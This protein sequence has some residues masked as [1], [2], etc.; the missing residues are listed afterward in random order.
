MPDAGDFVHLTAPFTFNGRVTGF[1]GDASSFPPIGPIGDPLFQLDLT[2]RGRARMHLV[3]IDERVAA[4]Q[5]RRMDY[6]FSAP[7]VVPEPG[8]LLLL[9]GGLAGLW[10]RRRRA[11]MTQTKSI[12]ADRG[13]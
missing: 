10:V 12:Q 2:G 5:F 1:A 11:T 4:Y 3:R 9:G 13:A 6:E 7:A 8:T